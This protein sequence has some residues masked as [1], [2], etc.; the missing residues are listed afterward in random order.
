MKI[1]N[2]EVKG[3]LFFSHSQSDSC[4]V[5]IGFIGNMSFEVSIK[6]EDETGVTYL[7]S[8][9]HLI[10]LT[11]QSSSIH[12]MYQCQIQFVIHFH[13]IHFTDLMQPHCLIH[14]SSNPVS[15]NLG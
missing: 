1:S 3:K 7:L 9:F 12:S 10:Y 15:G 5:A 6:K 8:H 2:N 14:I 13:L 11:Y 4:G